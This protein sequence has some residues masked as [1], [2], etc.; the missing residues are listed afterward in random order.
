[1][2]APSGRH[3]SPAILAEH[4][5]SGI[6]MLYPFPGKPAVGLLIEGAV[7]RLTLRAYVGKAVTQPAELP[8]ECQRGSNVR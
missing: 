6:T 7:P 4:V 2:N 5:D 8:Q 1:M 3:L